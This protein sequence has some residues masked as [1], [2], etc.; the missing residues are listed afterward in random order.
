MQGHTKKTN[1]SLRK[2]STCFLNISLSLDKRLTPVQNTQ[3]N[4][5]LIISRDAQCFQS[6]HG[7][8]W[9]LI[10]KKKQKNAINLKCNKTSRNTADM[11][12]D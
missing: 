12:M 10:V 1:C 11:V 4:C 2:G 8:I 3:T 9:I 7:A 6:N 5:F